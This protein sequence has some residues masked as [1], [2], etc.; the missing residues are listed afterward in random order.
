MASAAAVRECVRGQCSSIDEE[1]ALG[2]NLIDIYE[3]L[4]T[5]STAKSYTAMAPTIVLSTFP[6]QEVLPALNSLF[7]YVDFF[8]LIV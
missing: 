4:N 8:F 5:M 6:E 2:T 7:H 1:D 3:H